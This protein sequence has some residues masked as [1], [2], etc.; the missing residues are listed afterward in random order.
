MN[1]VWVRF[2][3]NVLFRAVCSSPSV[4]GSNL[5]SSEKISL[6]TT[7][8]TVS[9]GMVH[10]CNLNTK[11]LYCFKW[12]I[13]HLIFAD[14]ALSTL[15]HVTASQEDVVTL[16]N[17]GGDD[18]LL[19]HYIC[20]YSIHCLAVYH[21]IWE[22]ACVA[23]FVAKIC[24]LNKGYL[25]YSINRMREIFL[26]LSKWRAAPFLTW[27]K[28]EYTHTMAVDKGVLGGSRNTPKFSVTWT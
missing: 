5:L 11:P 2:V 8:N 23:C 6:M 18:V 26:N 22:Y 16:K 28:V 19:G 10:T 27:C 14:M 7:P 17:V 20:V 13:W 3:W 4:V 15:L 21:L 12:Y 9:A 24:S 25:H 1:Y